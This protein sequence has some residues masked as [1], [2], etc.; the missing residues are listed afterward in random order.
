[1]N[2]ITEESFTE[3]EKRMMEGWSSNPPPITEDVR[4]YLVYLI[5]KYGQLAESLL[6][7]AA[8][9]GETYDGIVNA[10][11]A[12]AVETLM[13]MLAQTLWDHDKKTA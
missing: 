5:V 9:L 4:K 2:D 3:F 1:M 7:K 11:S 12:G 10:S 8:F 13:G 6:E